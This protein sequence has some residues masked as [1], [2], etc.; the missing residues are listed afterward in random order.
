VSAFYIRAVLASTLS[1]TYG[2]YSGY[3]HYENVPREPGSEEYLDS[4]KYEIRPRALDGPMLPFLRHLNQIRREHPALQFLSNV[5]FLGTENDALIAYAKRT[6]DDILIAIVNMDPHHAQE[7]TC[8]VPY[9]L[10]LP[11]A[12]AVED[13]LSGEVWD[14]RLGRNYVRLDP[15]HRVA[16]LLH[17]KSYA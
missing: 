15:H 16:H 8:I 14:W 7:G 9:E 17:V 3:E 11:P 12:F 13:L 10:G 5:H 2:I 6:G 4:E 1:P